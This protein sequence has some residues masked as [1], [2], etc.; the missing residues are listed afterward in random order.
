MLGAEREGLAV[1]GKGD[2]TGRCGG[3]GAAGSLQEQQPAA[4]LAV[5]KEGAG[6]GLDFWYPLEGRTNP[7]DTT[8][9]LAR[10]ARS[11]G[12]QIF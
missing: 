8:M 11:R 1:D 2:E 10:A 12:A 4:G 6:G 3:E 7:V 5:A 9:A